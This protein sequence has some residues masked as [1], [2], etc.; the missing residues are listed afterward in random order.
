MKELFVAEKAPGDTLD[1]GFMWSDWLN[2][3]RLVDSF[4]GAEEGL[5]AMGSFFTDQISVIWLSGGAA[6]KT[7][8]VRNRIRT[9][10]GRVVERPLLLTVTESP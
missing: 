8:T 5:V 9:L 6:G 7:Y 1:Y 4:W 10:A 3:D 2:G